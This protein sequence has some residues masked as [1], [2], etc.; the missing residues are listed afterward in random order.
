L[1]AIGALVL[2]GRDV[3]EE[4]V[5]SAVVIPVDPFHR[6]VIDIRWCAAGRC[7]TGFAIR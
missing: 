4:A 1:S 7:G 2:L 5:P 3:V 6:G